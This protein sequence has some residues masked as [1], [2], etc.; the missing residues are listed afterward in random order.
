MKVK[1][2]TNIDLHK[3]LIVSNF[4][5]GICSIMMATTYNRTLLTLITFASSFCLYFTHI[6]INTAFMRRGSENVKFY[7]TLSYISFNFGS[8]LGPFLISKFGIPAC[9]LLGVVVICL[10]FVYIF[11]PSFPD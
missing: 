6:L 5:S 7:M 9:I 3:G 11:L 4:G 10:G 1:V 8:C 2:L